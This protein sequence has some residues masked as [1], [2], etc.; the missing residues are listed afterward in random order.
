MEMA[1]TT[2]KNIKFVEILVD[3]KH[4]GIKQRVIIYG[5]TD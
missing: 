3:V 4:L 1:T 5:I 2:Q